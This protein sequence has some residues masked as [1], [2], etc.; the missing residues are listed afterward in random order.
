MIEC[1]RQVIAAAAE[2]RLIALATPMTSALLV[3]RETRALLRMQHDT[4]MMAL[5]QHTSVIGG[6]I[7]CRYNLRRA[8]EIVR[9]SAL[10]AP[11]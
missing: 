7:G 5:G 8:L 10:R 9:T 2:S 4:H 1:S 6:A 11:H 3:G